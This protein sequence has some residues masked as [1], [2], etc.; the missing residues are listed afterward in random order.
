MEMRFLEPIRWKLIYSPVGEMLL[1]SEKIIDGSIYQDYSNLEKFNDDYIIEN[2]V[3]ANSYYHSDVR[4]VLIIF[5]Q[6]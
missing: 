2:E 6:I 1:L 4:V 3:Y 5:L